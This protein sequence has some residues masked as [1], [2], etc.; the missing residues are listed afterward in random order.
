MGTF[1]SG[2]RISG[3]KVIAVAPP[4]AALGRRK[5]IILSESLGVGLGIVWRM[6]VVVLL[7]F[8]T[9]LALDIRVLVFAWRW[10]YYIVRSNRFS[11]FIVRSNR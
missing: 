3:M 11:D 1:G 5:V 9:M 7:A 2:V 10:I 6:S 8:V 4:M